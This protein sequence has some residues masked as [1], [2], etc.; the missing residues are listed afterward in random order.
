MLLSRVGSILE[1]DSASNSDSKGWSCDSRVDS[2]RLRDFHDNFNALSNRFCDIIIKHNLSCKSHNLL[3]KS[4]NL[5]ESIFLEMEWLQLWLLKI[6]KESAFGESESR[7]RP[8]PTSFYSAAVPVEAQFFFTFSKI[9]KI[10][11]NWFMELKCT[12]AGHRKSICESSASAATSGLAPP[13]PGIFF[14]GFFSPPQKWLQPPPTLVPPPT[15]PTQ[16]WTLGPWSVFLS[17]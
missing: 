9:T 7:K 2:R 15:W 3:W 13:C 5:L 8:D 10:S 17:Y 6:A 4:C 11:F 14:Q 12:S 1:I 16:P